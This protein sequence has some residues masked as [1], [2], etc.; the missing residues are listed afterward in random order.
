MKVEVE[1][2]VHN[3]EIGLVVIALTIHEGKGYQ[4]CDGHNES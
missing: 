4:N 1:I 3:R 2:I